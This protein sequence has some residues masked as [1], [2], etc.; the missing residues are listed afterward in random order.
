[1]IEFF[2]A[3]ADP[4]V[5]ATVL[6]VMTPLLLAALGVLISDRAGVLNIGMEGIMLSGALIGVLVSAATANPFLGLFAALIGGGLLGALMAFFINGLGT[7]FIITGIALNMAA[8]A[9]TTLGLFL[10]TGDKG[11][12]GAL[13]SGVLPNLDIPLL[14]GVPILGPLLSGHHMLTYLAILAVPAVAI[15]LARTPFG[16]HIRAVGSDPKAAAAAGISRNRVQLYTLTLSGVFGGAAGAY[17][18]MGYVS[19]FAQNM[20]AG[21]GFIALAAEVMGMGTA[22]G[23]F[24][25]AAV[26]GIAETVA[27][28]MQTKGLP[29]ELM[30][31]IPYIVPAVM[32]TVYAARRQAKARK[33]S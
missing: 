16:L 15:M 18:S 22:W 23:T 29:S 31:M 17:L 14:G 12:S 4:A 26:L 13:K 2:G 30:Q 6:R 33:I 19:W 21:R 3:I 10:A 32:L 8:L 20:T 27:I 9:A 28:T 7:Q 11:M 24:A 25:A 5:F 1:M